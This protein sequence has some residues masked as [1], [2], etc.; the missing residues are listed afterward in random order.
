DIR[1]HLDLHRRVCHALAVKDAVLIDAAVKEIFLS[2]DLHVKIRSRGQESLIGGSRRD[3]T[4][5]HQRYGCDLAALQ[6]GAL[7]VREVSRGV[8]D[9]QAVV[10]RGVARAK[11][12]S[13]ES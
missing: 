10:G 6:L 4:G 5:V 9:T 13:A 3:G 12:W 11:T 8:T 7:P 1:S 2:F